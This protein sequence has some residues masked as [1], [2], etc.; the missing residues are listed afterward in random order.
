MSIV[1]WHIAN[2]TVLLSL[3]TGF[4]QRIHS[5]YDHNFGDSKGPAMIPNHISGFRNIVES[6]ANS[7][8]RNKTFTIIPVNFSTSP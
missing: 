7:E 3:L 5:P 1:L 8:I 2:S 4:F 6:L